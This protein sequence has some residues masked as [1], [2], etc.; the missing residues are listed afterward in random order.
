MLNRRA[1]ALA[2]F[3]ESSASISRSPEL[4][5]S[6]DGSLSVGSDGRSFHGWVPPGYPATKNTSK[7]AQPQNLRFCIL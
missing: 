5:R 7:H 6:S 1:C 3:D 2:C 4:R